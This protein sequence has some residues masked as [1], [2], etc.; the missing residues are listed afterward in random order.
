MAT[1]VTQK[2]F[3]KEDERESHVQPTRGFKRSKGLYSGIH[4]HKRGKNQRDSINKRERNRLEMLSISVSSFYDLCEKVYLVLRRRSKRE[5][6][7][8]RYFVV[9]VFFQTPSHRLLQKA[10]CFVLLFRRTK[11]DLVIRTKI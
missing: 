10:K 4:P 5:T 7:F 2:R 8:P 11:I 6:F 1:N 3:Q 9:L